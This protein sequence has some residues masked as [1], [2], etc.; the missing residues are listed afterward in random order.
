MI[1]NSVYGKTME[2]LRKRIHVRLVNNAKNYEK[3]VSKLNFVSQKF[4]NKNLLAI[5]EIKQVLTRNKTIY[6][7]FSVLDLSKYLMYGY[8]YKYIKR[9]FDAKLLFTDI[10]ILVC[11]IKTEK[12]VYE[13]FYKDKDLFD[14]SNYLKDSMFYDLTNKNEICKIKY[15]SKEKKM[16]GLLH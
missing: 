11:E 3:Y 10:D 14:I 15:E 13:D 12:V 16:M 9:K 8:H 1:I 5:H 7:G 2:N 6:V 4:F